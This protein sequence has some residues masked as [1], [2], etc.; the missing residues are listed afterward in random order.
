[1]GWQLI[2]QLLIILLV[3]VLAAASLSL[4]SVAVRPSRATLRAAGVTLLALTV[5][6]I[7]TAVTSAIWAQI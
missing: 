3:L 4:A 2:I 1:M 5:L 6:A 7:L